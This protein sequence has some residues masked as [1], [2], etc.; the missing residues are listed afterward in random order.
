MALVAPLGGYGVYRG[1]R[2][3]VG[4]QRGLIFAA[5]FAG[6]CSTVLAAL[7][8]AGQLAFAGTAT[9]SVVFPA[10]VN[11]HLLIG[12]GEGLITGLVVVAIARVRPELLEPIKSASLPCNYKELAGY[13]LLLA[14]GL[15]LFVA[16]FASP[17]PD[18]LEQVAEKLG[19]AGKAVTKPM[20]SAPIPNYQVPGMSSAVW[21]TVW[22]GAI[23]TMVA[24]LLA[25]LGACWLVP[26][27]ET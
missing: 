1:I 11:V 19:F 25:W 10:M 17:W 21:A 18:G 27:R 16:P 13:G 5:I 23:G 6:W 14:L 7:S 8:C 20:V 15:A 4:D 12:V 9:W 26:K 24:F 3:C 2:A 22:A